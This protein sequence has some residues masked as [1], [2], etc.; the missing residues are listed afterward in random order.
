MERWHT[1]PLLHAHSS[2]AITQSFY[3]SLKSWRAR[4]KT[5]PNSKPPRRRRWFFKVIWKSAAIKLK[6]GKLVL[7]NG[8]KNEPLIVSW[9]YPK[10]KIIELGWNKAS[11]CY[12]LRVCYSVEVTSS[13]NT[14]KVAAADLGEIH[15]MVIADGVNT[16]IFNGRHLRSVRRYQNKLKAKLSKL[17]DKKKKGSQRRR[18]LIKSKQKQLTQ[19]KNQIRDI[20]HKLTSRAV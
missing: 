14:N 13:I 10:P 12:E 18:K 15:P 2:D 16:D 19:I 11:Q 7:S 9:T 5:D 1:S 20:E 6:N 17:I 8:K 3:S 4:R